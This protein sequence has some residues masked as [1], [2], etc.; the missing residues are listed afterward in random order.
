M[1]A[2]S[3]SVASLAFLSVV[4]AHPAAEACGGFFVAPKRPDANATTLVSDASMVAL[5]RDGT[6]TVVSMSMNYKGPAADFAMV[7]PVPVVLEKENVKTLPRDLFTKLDRLTAP[8]LVEYWE[9]DPCS[10][11]ADGKPGTSGGGVGIVPP[12]GI[13]KGFG[14]GGAVKVEAQFAV[15][16]Y[17]IVILSASES[18]ALETWLRDNKYNI[19]EGASETLAPYVKEQMKF[20]VAK[21]DATKV[22]KDA[23]GSVMLSP[24]RFQFESKDFR[25]PLRVGLINNKDKQDLL[26]F[27][28]ASGRYEAA[29]YA[30]VPIPTNL[31]L[32]AES[33]P[34]FPE[35]YATLFDAAVKKAGGKAIVTEYAWRSN[36]CN[37]CTSAVLTTSDLMTLGAGGTGSV[38]ESFGSGSLGLKGTGVGGGTG[39]GI[40]LGSLGSTGIGKPAKGPSPK[41]K[42]GKV[43]VVGKL[44]PEV[45]RRIMRANFPRYRACYDKGFASDPTLAG[46]VTFKFK[47]ESTG[48]IASTSA[49]DT[50]KDPKIGACL[51]TVLRTLSFPEPESGT[52]DVTYPL[53]FEP[54]GASTTTGGLI[55]V[56][57]AYAAPLVITRLHVR[58]DKTTLGDDIVFRAVDPIAGG[59]EV[60]AADATRP[61]EG[62]KA[63]PNNEFQARYTIRHSWAGPVACGTP[64]RGVWLTQPPA[65]T[66]A[67]G[68]KTATSLASA[69]RGNIKLSSY[70]YAGLDDLK[71]WD[72]AGG[73]TKKVGA[74]PKK[75][76]A[77]EAKPKARA[78]GCEVGVH[79]ESTAALATLGFVA[80]AIARRRR[81]T[82]S[83]SPRAARGRSRPSA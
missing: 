82:T 38:G 41:M 40:G 57:S 49:K 63:S 43:D 65:G 55:G 29:N 50:F 37:P 62:T 80:L 27:V 56:L 42:E 12:T 31:D 22:S 64:V 3:R 8:R 15:G 33:A 59:R 75:E 7:V 74:P 52:V 35:I 47:I 11:T 10:A 81:T 51:L 21:V 6:R 25:L 2:F 19:P 73:Y 79:E 20:F 34:K 48:A 28:L 70:V 77:P 30:N 26:I 60:F 53:D 32:T 9:K 72:E 67:S 44:P 68:P 78:C 39:D 36:D 5:H 17:E 1:S 13:G 24:L 54:P 69:P 83:T 23:D 76:D 4:F 66:T 16:E 45:V 18:D 61:E 46:N 58:Y 71:S 14:G